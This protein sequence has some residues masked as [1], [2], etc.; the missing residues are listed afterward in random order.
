MRNIFISYSRT[1]LDK[2]KAIKDDI[3][4]S[5]QQRC[6]MDLE[7]IEAGLPRFTQ[8]IIDGI[9]E[10]KVFLFMRTAQS[11]E[12]E[13]ALR[14]LNFASKRV[15][16]V[17]IINADDSQMSDEFEFMYGLTDTITWD[18][19]PQREKFLQDIRK[20]LGKEYKTSN[21]LSAEELFIKAQEYMDR[22]LFLE[23]MVYLKKAANLGYAIAQY[24]LGKMYSNGIGCAQDDHEAL[25][26]YTLAAKQGYADAQN[27]L[28]EMYYFGWGLNRDYNEAA[29]WYCSAAEQ[30]LAIAQNNLGLLYDNGRGVP[31]NDEEAAKWYLKAAEQ[32]LPEAQC[33]LG[34]MYESGRGVPHNE[35]EAI[36]WF[37]KA[38]VQGD[39]NALEIYKKMIKKK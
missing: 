11:Q 38:A 23:A 21:K 29:K 18:N 13:F 25:K 9:K 17:V 20:W 10:C 15:E 1:N 7:G 31:Q 32:G 24:K 14:E 8:A 28:G 30:G 19:I 6:W 36:K 27:S 12:S 34:W 22:D 35:N 4:K 2:V 37:H 33:N 26:W 16:H 5:T 3:E 39:A